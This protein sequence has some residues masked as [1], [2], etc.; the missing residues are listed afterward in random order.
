MAD[1]RLRGDAGATA[2]LTVH[3][4]FWG[5]FLVLP[6]RKLPYR[7]F[8]IT[9]HDTLNQRNRSGSSPYCPLWQH[10]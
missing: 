8:K 4:Y 5:E 2:T 1:K 9:P 6:E 3:S 7:Q 10:K